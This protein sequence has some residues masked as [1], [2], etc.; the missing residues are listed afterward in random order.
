[1]NGIKHNS[2]KVA[3]TSCVLKTEC[4]KDSA[5]A[6]NLLHPSITAKVQVLSWSPPLGSRLADSRSVL[7][8]KVSHKDTS[9]Y[10]RCYQAFSQLILCLLRQVLAI[11]CLHLGPSL[12][13]SGLGSNVKCQW[14]GASLPAPPPIPAPASLFGP[15]ACS[16]TCWHL[17]PLQPIP[18]FPTLHSQCPL[19]LTSFLCLTLTSAATG[20]IIIIWRLIECHDIIYHL[21]GIPARDSEPEAN[22]E[23]TL[24]KPTERH[25][26]RWSWRPRKH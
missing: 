2:C 16:F 12:M 8:S 4:T 18:C 11:V 7:S 14:A 20:Q 21:W 19:V 22:S 9:T 13:D 15:R 10:W 3:D 1:M 26:T 25:S 17:F 24:G 5:T 6:D 23:E